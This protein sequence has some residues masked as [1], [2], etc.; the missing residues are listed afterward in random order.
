[1]NAFVAEAGWLDRRY[2][3]CLADLAS[4]EGG[5]AEAIELELWDERTP[6]FANLLRQAHGVWRQMAHIV[7][8]MDWTNP[9]ADRFRPQHADYRT[10]RQAQLE[11]IATI[12]R[13][14]QLYS[15]DVDHAA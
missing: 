5:I 10:W 11:R 6:K 7:E 15:L 12:G 1:V 3:E 8:L 14:C 2:S 4:I 13:P 9:A